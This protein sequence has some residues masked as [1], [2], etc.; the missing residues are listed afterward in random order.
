MTP[1][2][3]EVT[4]GTSDPGTAA[5]ASSSSRKSAVRMLVSCRQK[6]RTC[7]TNPSFGCAIDGS[8]VGDSMWSEGRDEVIGHPRHHSGDECLPDAGDHE[9]ADR[10]QQRTPDDVDEPDVA[11]QPRDGTG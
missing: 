8:G 9:D 11:L 5:K 6:N 4:C 3:S 2:G 7:P 10:N 1:F